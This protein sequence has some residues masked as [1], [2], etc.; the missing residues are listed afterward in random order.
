[1]NV[2]SKQNQ[3]IFNMIFDK[4]YK[5]MTLLFEN[6]A[7]IDDVVKNNVDEN[8][9]LHVCKKVL[10]LVKNNNVS[11]NNK[12]RIKKYIHKKVS[13]QWETNIE[14]MMQYFAIYFSFCVDNLNHYLHFN[15]VLYII[16]TGKSILW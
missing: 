12:S 6:G 5:A 16:I 10:S 2:E 11:I 8:I 14:K 1:M 9:N 3:N 7:K 4:Q 13:D 15:W